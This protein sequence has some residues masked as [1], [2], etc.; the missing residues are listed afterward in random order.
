MLH[1]LSTLIVFSL[2]GGCQDVGELRVQPEQ[3]HI[4]LSQEIQGNWARVCVIG[5]YSDNKQASRIV[6]FAIDV[7]RSSNIEMSDA[8]VL[9]AVIDARQSAR[10][11]RIERN[12][13]DF[14]AL[15]GECYRR[16]HA[17]FRVDGD[18][19]VSPRRES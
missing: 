19:A 9:L 15:S 16:T 18:G 11:L 12:I 10:L 2:L 14:T 6:G 8:I 4:D 7:E 13:A 3:S 1:R 5:P 17:V